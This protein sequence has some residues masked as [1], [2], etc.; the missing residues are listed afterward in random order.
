MLDNSIFARWSHFICFSS[1]DIFCFLRALFMIYDAS[2]RGVCDLPR[3]IKAKK[4][5]KG[6]G[7]LRLV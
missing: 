2:T 6:E 1:H 7:F 3:N 4:K 5:K